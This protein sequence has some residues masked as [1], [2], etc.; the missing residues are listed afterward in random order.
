M[1][2]SV[3]PRVPPQKEGPKLPYG[4]KYPFFPSVR[5]LFRAGVMESSRLQRR[6]ETARCKDIR[7]N[8]QQPEVEMLNLQLPN[9]ITSRRSRGQKSSLDGTSRAFCKILKLLAKPPSAAEARGVQHP[10]PAAA[11]AK[12]KQEPT[13]GAPIPAPISNCRARPMSGERLAKGPR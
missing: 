6:A 2:G 3:G 10:P 11:K 13:P 7:R 1:E 8:Y 4:Q 9:S 5:L 12:G